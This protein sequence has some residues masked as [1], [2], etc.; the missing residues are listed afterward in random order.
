MK[1]AL[2]VLSS[3]VQTIILWILV[4]LSVSLFFFL[5]P[6]FFRFFHLSRLSFSL[7]LSLTNLLIFSLLS[8]YS[9][10][11][12]LFLRLLLW[13]H[14]TILTTTIWLRRDLDLRLLPSKTSSY[15]C[16]PMSITILGSFPLIIL[17][18]FIYFCTFSLLAARHCLFYGLLFLF[19]SF[20]PIDVFH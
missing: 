14:W 1:L 11:S 18:R 4:G 3:E 6:L 5:S 9:T 10:R 12:L 17:L 15:C 19:R 8:S 16:R 20:S 13:H 2:S 7:S